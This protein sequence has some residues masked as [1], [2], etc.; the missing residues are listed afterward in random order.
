MNPRRIKIEIRTGRTELSPIQ[1][2]IMRDSLSERRLLAKK[3]AS[4]A[5]ARK[6]MLNS[7]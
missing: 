4:I 7:I 3:S 1:R 2:A 5:V 6:T